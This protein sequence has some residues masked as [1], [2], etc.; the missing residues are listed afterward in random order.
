MREAARVYTE[1]GAQA[2]VVDAREIGANGTIYGGTGHVADW[3]A[4]RLLVD[5]GLRV[6]LAGGLTPANVARAIET[7]NPWGVDVVS[8]V[9]VETRKGAKDAG[10][11]REFIANARGAATRCNGP[12]ISQELQ[13]IA[14]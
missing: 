5:E 4:A 10:K 12:V 8:G 6:I 11:V 9:E 2:L 3:S 14:R 13:L 7:V 1:A